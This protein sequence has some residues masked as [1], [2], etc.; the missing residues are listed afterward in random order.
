[1]NTEIN[2]I[3]FLISSIIGYLARMKIKSKCSCCECEIERDD[4][5]KVQ[6]LSVVK[7][8]KTDSS[9]NLESIDNNN[10]NEKENNKS[11]KQGTL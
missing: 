5:N 9:R 6:R 10:N 11:L 1:M 7:K 2:V 4:N 8:N 3:L